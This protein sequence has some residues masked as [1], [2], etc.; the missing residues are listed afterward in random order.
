MEN[1]I[2]F[3]NETQVTDKNFKLLMFYNKFFYIK[4]SN[5]HFH[6]SRFNKFN[7]HAHL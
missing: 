1:K 6:N 7:G 4:V 3:Y 5:L 2:F